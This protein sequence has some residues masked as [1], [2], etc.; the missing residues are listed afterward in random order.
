MLQ[1]GSNLLSSEGDTKK[2]P[3]ELFCVYWLDTHSLSTR[4]C[5]SIAWVG[6]ARYDVLPYIG[7][8]FTD[9]A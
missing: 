6:I 3:F 5:M 8:P 2:L 4:P 1:V 9:S 7:H